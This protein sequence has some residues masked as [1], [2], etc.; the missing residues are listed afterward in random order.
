MTKYAKITEN[1]TIK[2]APR[3]ISGVSNW[4]EDTVA[5]LQAGYLPVA[6]TMAPE[7]QYIS[8]YKIENNQVV[9]IFTVLPEPDYQE[10][11]R[12]AYPD[13]EEQLD[14]LYW[15]KVEGTNIWQETI[16]AIKAKYPKPEYVIESIKAEENES[17]VI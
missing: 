8:G 9:P 3:D 16:S 7:G 14:M 13:I 6:E 2:Y 5:V 10:L 1:G 4:I 15:D 17:D 11:R 12:R